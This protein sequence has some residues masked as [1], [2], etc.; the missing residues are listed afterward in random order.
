MPGYLS[1][2]RDADAALEYEWHADIRYRLHRRATIGLN[3]RN[4]RTN[5][6]ALSTEQYEEALLGLRLSF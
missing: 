1:N 2:D 4:G 5:D 3:W 6:S